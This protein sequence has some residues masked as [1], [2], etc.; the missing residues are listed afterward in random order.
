MGKQIAK[1]DYPRQAVL[2]MGWFEIFGYYF[3]CFLPFFR[4]S[5]ERART[6]ILVAKHA[7]IQVINFAAIN[8]RM[9]YNISGMLS[10]SF[11]P[12]AA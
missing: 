1:N 5:S 6:Y 2:W 8:I 3:E 4:I 12:E 9:A 10:S 7:A 11:Q